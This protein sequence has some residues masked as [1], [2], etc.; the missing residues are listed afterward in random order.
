MST[1]TIDIA[2]LDGGLVATSED[3]LAALA[4]RVGGPLLRP[5]DEGWDAAVL[6][7]NGMAAKVP[8]AVLQPTSAAGV[9]EAVRFAAERGLLLSIKGGGHNIAGT[10]IAADGLTLD[11]SRMRTRRCRRRR[12]AGPRGRRLPDL[13]RRR[14]HPGARPGRRPRLRLPHR[15]RRPHPRRWVRL[16]HPPVRVDGRQPRR[17]GDRHRRRSDPHRQRHRER[18]AVLGPAGRRRQLRRG[19]PVH[20]PAVRGGPADHGRAHPVGRSPGRGGAG[21]LPGADRVGAS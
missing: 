6:I 13:R 7:W 20:L 3:D 1:G 18:R 14:R 17:G 21:R 16:P 15:R 10:S 5:G 12:P 8:A 4:G 11:M 19:H 9:V 2:G